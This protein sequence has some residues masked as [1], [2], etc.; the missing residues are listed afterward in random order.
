MNNYLL[1][2][3]VRSTGSWYEVR[4][5]ESDKLISC[6]MPGKFRLDGM[7]L[8]NPVAVGDMVQINIEKDK[9][10]IIK[11]IEPRNNYLIRQ[12]PRKK[13]HIHIIASNVDQ[14]ILITTIVSPKLKQGFIDRFLIMTEP[15]D[16][17]ALIVFNKIDLYDEVAHAL[18]DEMIALYED[19]GYDCLKLSAI[20]GEGVEEFNDKI[21]NKT[22][23]ITGQSGV[24]K[25]TLLNHLS[26]KLALRTNYLSDYTGK[27]MHTT[28][29][30]ELFDIGDGRIII[31]TPGIK[32]LSFN[33][34]E[35]MDVAHNF[36]EIFIYSKN[37]KYS[38]CTHKE[39]PHCAVKK[40]IEEG[41]ISA[42]R[43]YNYLQIVE[44]IEAQNYWERN[45]G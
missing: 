31:D 29:F 5:I 40:A 23:L 30:A 39:E 10:G 41:H 32:T 27:G 26:D 35:P 14:A 25:T 34:L 12:S 28:T 19:I 11:K 18:C 37:C 1:G 21:K 20:T 36:K 33:H 42:M 15:Y 24:G 22:S 16:I 6:R 38:N 13:H 9:K 44:E 8:T 3:V 2:K 43:Y 7:K 17:P 45:E 4:L